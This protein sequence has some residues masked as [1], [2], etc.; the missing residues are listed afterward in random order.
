MCEDYSQATRPG[1]TCVPTLESG[2]RWRRTH[3][4]PTKKASSRATS[5]AAAI[6]TSVSCMAA[7]KSAV[8]GPDAAQARV[9]QPLGPAAA[10]V[11]GAGA[12]PRAG[13]LQPSRSAIDETICTL[14]SRRCLHQR[15]AC[16]ETCSLAVLRASGAH[17]PLPARTQ[18]PAE[19]LQR[20]PAACRAPSRPP[21]RPLVH[22]AARRLATGRICNVC[23]LGSVAMAGSRRCPPCYR[24]GAAVAAPPPLVPVD[25]KDFT[26]AMECIQQARGMQSE[27]EIKLDP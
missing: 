13:G 4:W 7:G 5:A 1:C 27:R 12:S 24:H 6:M 3:H 22:C 14:L 26:R 25:E 2:G 23:P 17:S 10:A 21:G 16:Q 20:S 19:P 18:P 9:P 11:R 15:P 8:G